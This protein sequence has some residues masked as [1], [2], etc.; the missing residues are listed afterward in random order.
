MCDSLMTVVQYWIYLVAGTQINAHFPSTNGL[1]VMALDGNLFPA[2]G[3]RLPSGLWAPARLIAQVRQIECDRFVQ[4]RLGRTLSRDKH[5][6]DGG[7][8]L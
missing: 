6:G 7:R 2:L 3:H 4:M 1:P 5:L 8:Q